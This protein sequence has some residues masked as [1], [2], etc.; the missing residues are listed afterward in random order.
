MLSLSSDIHKNNKKQKP[1]EKEK[2]TEEFAT[3]ITKT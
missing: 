3:Y 2:E 1:K